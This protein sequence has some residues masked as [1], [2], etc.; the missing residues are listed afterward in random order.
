MKTGDKYHLRD[1]QEVYGADQVQDI[2]K[3][4]LQEIQRKYLKSFRD[5]ETV[6]WLAERQ[7]N[8]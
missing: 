1:G 2:E 5:L 6:L 4:T 7:K 3:H 8:V